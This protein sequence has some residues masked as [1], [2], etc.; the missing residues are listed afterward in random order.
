[1]SLT[2]HETTKVWTSWK[3]IT[4]LDPDKKNTEKI[5]KTVVN[6]GTDAIMIS[7][8]L[9]VDR[10]NAY[11]LYNMIKDYDIP[12]IQEPSSPYCLLEDVDYI[13]VPSVLNS[14]DTMWICG[15]HKDWIREENSKI[16]WDQIVP[17]AYIILNQ[18]SSVCK[19][20]KAM[21]NLDIKDVVAYSVL[22][23]QFFKFPIIYIEY[24]GKY[25]D[26]EVVKA[27]SESIKDAKLF[28]GG[29][30]NSKEKADE[31]RKYATI[32]VGNVVYEDL[33]AYLSTI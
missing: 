8:T 24:S 32:V 33:D 23:E 21:H 28:Y 13:F 17:E 14:I 25:G 5:I 10:E 4:K 2:Y 22:A 27:V 9:G 11:N 30:I 1:M 31:M 7:G 15:Y 3:H 19:L 20:T 12:K 16:R 6:S 29:G 18:E 26:K